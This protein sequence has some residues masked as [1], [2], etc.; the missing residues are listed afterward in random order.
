MFCSYDMNLLSRRQL[1]V[2]DLPGLSA[3]ID[4]R[5][6]L[7]PSDNS[8]IRSSIVDDARMMAREISIVDNTRHGMTATAAPPRCVIARENSA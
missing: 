3:L 1:A 8:L 5:G 2:N 6:S 7:H 4:D